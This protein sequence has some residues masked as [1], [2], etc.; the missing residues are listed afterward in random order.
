MRDSGRMTKTLLTIPQA[1]AVLGLS[2]KTLWQWRAER[3][4]GI[5]ALGRSVRIAQ[6]E[7]DRL[8]EEGSL[9]AA[10]R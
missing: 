5:V 9:P 3:R 7:L 2:P 1:A 10:S 8:I 6:S 4:I